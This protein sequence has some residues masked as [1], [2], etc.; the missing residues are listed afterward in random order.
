MYQV[1]VRDHRRKWRPVRNRSATCVT[2]PEA[3]AFARS[4][5]PDGFIHHATVRI[6]ERGSTVAVSKERIAVV[7]HGL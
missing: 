2:L 7:W 4:L 5:D 3:V 6:M 1:E